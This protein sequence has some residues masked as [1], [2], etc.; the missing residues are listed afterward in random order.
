MFIIT[1]LMIM[2]L[3]FLFLCN[4]N[5]CGIDGSRNLMI[6]VFGLFSS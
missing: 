4:Q 5:G 6:I 1:E 3:Q 2:D